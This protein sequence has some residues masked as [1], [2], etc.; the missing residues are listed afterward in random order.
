M[1]KNLLRKIKIKNE[2]VYQFFFNN[3]NNNKMN[4]LKF[5]TFTGDDSKIGNVTF[6]HLDG[7][8]YVKG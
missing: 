2:N 8:K 3:K 7:T 6:K 5:K 1:L 4:N